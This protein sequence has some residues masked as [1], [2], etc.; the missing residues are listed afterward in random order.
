M[1]QPQISNWH[2]TIPLGWQQQGRLTRPRVCTVL[3]PQRALNPFPAWQRCLCPMIADHTSGYLRETSEAIWTTS[4]CDPS[5]ELSYPYGLCL[6]NPE[7]TRCLQW[8][9][10][11][12]ISCK[13]LHAETQL[14]VLRAPLSVE[15][16]A[17]DNTDQPEG[18]RKTTF[19]LEEHC[20][21]CLCSCHG[22]TNIK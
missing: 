18:C 19:N 17:K 7:F 3:Q 16:T 21:M 8:G 2:R 10:S 9:F 20:T 5:V 6:F 14:M 1:N 13:L 22:L 15:V 12:G 4:S 11:Q